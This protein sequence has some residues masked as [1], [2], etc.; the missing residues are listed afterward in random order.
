MHEEG[1]NGSQASV[2]AVEGKTELGQRPAGAYSRPGNLRR[3]YRK[4]KSNGGAAGVD[5]MT[6]DETAQ[7]LRTHPGEKPP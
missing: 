4:V 6:I 3:A 5:G 1:C 7:R 2:Q